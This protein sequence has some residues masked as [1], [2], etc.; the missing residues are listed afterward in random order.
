MIMQTNVQEV[1][2]EPLTGGPGHNWK[3]DHGGHSGSD[4]TTYPVITLPPGSGPWLIHFTIQNQGNSI[5]FGPDPV[6][7]QPG[8]KPNSHIIDPQI[9]AVYP[10]G[11]GGKELFV[12]DK[13]DNPAQQTLYYSLQ[14][15][16]HG[17]VDPIIQNGGH[18]MVGPYPTATNT[19]TLSYA[20]L[21]VALVVTLIVG[22]LVGRMMGR[23]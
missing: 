12:L 21:G 20:M 11:G 16:G 17:Q 14:F 9:N 23:R 1:T 22:A 19:V 7:V 4:P 15:S 18:P 13:N 5:T 6:W 2:L 8:S 3:V 10:P